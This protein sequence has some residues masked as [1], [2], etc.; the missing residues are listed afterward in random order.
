MMDMEI[1]PKEPGIDLTVLESKIKQAED[2]LDKKANQEIK[3]TAQTIFVSTAISQS[4]SLDSFVVLFGQVKMIWR[5]AKIYNQRPALR[6]LVKLYA[7]VAVTSFAAKAIEDI[8]FGLRLKRLGK[9]RP[10]CL[11]ILGA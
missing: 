9:Q 6:E 7:N 4:G 3:T 2:Q 10:H 11:V 5:I 8:D 1:D